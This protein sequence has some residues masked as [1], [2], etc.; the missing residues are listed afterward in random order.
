MHMKDAACK[1]YASSASH[2]LGHLLVT[3]QGLYAQAN[4]LQLRAHL[5]EF[6][7]VAACSNK[8]L[9]HDFARV[10]IKLGQICS[11]VRWGTRVYHLSRLRTLLYVHDEFLLLLLELS[12]LAIQL[13]LRLREGAL[14]LTQTLRRGHRSTKERFLCGP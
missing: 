9:C 10:L 6:L 8:V 11:G 13:A 5:V 7:H 4:R 14:M 3:S 1:T 12:A 2:S